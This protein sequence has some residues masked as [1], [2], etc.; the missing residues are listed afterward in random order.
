MKK[1]LLITVFLLA[2]NIV[3]AGEKDGT[4]TLTT[5]TFTHKGIEYT[6]HLY[7]PQGLPAGAPLVMVFHGYG[8]GTTPPLYY[9][10]NPVA[11]REGFAVCYP[12]GPKDFRGNHC[13][14]V[15]YSF[16]IEKGWDRD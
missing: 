14:A 9:G 2:C 4:G 7:K 6:Y 10:I 1:T 16:H 11:D 8:S 15:G 3:M 12:T 13:W 5:H